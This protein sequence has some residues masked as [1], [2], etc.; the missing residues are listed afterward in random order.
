MGR[1]T[2]KPRFT[3]A[4]AL[5][6]GRGLGYSE[7]VGFRIVSGTGIREFVENAATAAE[8]VDRVRAMIKRRWPCIRVITEG[9]REQSLSELESLAEFENESDDA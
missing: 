4:Q 1:V 5:P 9:G 3:L 6:S 8:A 7:P 2:S